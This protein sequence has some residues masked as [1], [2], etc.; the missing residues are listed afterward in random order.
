[1]SLALVVAFSATAVAQ[2]SAVPAVRPAQQADQT[3]EAVVKGAF[4]VPGAIVKLHGAEQVIKGELEDGARTINAAKQAGRGMKGAEAAYRAAEGF[5]QD[6]LAGAYR[7][8]A[9]VVYDAAAEEVID[10]AAK[11]AIVGAAPHLG[12]IG[13]VVVRA[14]T[15]GPGLVWSAGQAGWEAGKLI[16]QHYGN[17][18]FDAWHSRLPPSWQGVDEKSP[19]FQAKLDADTQAAIRRRMFEKVARENAEQQRQ[20]DSHAASQAAALQSAAEPAAASDGIRVLG[21]ILQGSLAAYA[22]QR[23][24]AG[25]VAASPRVCQLDPR[26]GCHPG[27]DEKSHPGGCKKC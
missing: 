1:M 3:N 26:T 20:L 12:K 25:V 9:Q 19:A 15:A 6:G 16:D 7:A 13:S 24:Q 14:G 10:E 27:H 8:G 4:G 2:T 11:R 22:Q 17:E 21:D 5:G 23:Q 18:I